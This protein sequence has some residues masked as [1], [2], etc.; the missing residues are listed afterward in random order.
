MV[1]FCDFCGFVGFRLC[2]TSFFLSLWYILSIRFLCFVILGIMAWDW[3]YSGLMDGMVLAVYFVCKDAY[4]PLSFLSPLILFHL[5]LFLLPRLIFSSHILISSSPSRFLPFSLIP[6][7]PVI[8]SH[9]P[10]LSPSI[11]YPSLSSHSFP[12][13]SHHRIFLS[14][15]QFLPFLLFLVILYYFFSHHPLPSLFHPIT[16][17]C[18]DGWAA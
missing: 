2:F 8:S 9:H 13:I 17:T 4:C 6:S 11:P 10:F 18:P 7:H 15:F 3:L 5:H 16:L 1:V 12:V 14:F